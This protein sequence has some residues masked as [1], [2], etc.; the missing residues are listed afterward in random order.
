[1]A[2]DPVRK[3]A[4]SRIK[5]RQNFWRMVAGF[6]IVNAIM[7]VIW[8]IS[9]RGYFWPGWVLFGTG[10]ATAY[11]ALAAYGPGRKPITDSQVDD[12]M[13]KMQGEQ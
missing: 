12:E 7:I 9:D 4:I 1:M 8:L 2:E 5:A 6:V 10:I 11:S 13:K 3:A